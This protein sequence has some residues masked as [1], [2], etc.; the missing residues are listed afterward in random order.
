MI[1]TPSTE[2]NK[3][4][5]IQDVKF[6]YYNSLKEYKERKSIFVTQENIDDFV[7]MIRPRWPHFVTKKTQQD[8]IRQFVNE[9]S[10]NANCVKYHQF[11]LNNGLLYN[12]RVYPLHKAKYAFYKL[13]EHQYVTCMH[14]FNYTDIHKIGIISIYSPLPNTTEFFQQD[15]LGR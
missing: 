7:I 10:Y 12:D 1:N 6:V 4:I 8:A 3:H 14:K 13:T 15:P 2:K 11:F 5:N 9:Y